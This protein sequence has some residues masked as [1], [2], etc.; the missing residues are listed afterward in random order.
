MIYPQNNTKLFIPIELDGSAG[1][2]VFKLAHRKQNAKVFWHIDESYIGETQNE[3]KL[4]V[5]PSIGKHVLTV[6]DESGEKVRL[7]FEVLK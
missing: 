5:K 1:R 2:V 7:E 3:H 6:M 4:A